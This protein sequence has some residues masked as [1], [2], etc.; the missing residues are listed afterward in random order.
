MY[1][2]AVLLIV[3]GLTVLVTQLIHI[4]LDFDR[5]I[6]ALEDEQAWNDNEI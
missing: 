4:V 6:R 5:R 3:V 1:F 2:A